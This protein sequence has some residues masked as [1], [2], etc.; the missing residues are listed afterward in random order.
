M[1]LLALLAPSALPLAVQPETAEVRALA[2]AQ[3]MLASPAH[4]HVLRFPVVRGEAAWRAD[5]D[6]P[7]WV[8]VE[9]ASARV[10]RADD[11]AALGLPDHEPADAAQS[12]AIGPRQLD[13]AAWPIARFEGVVRAPCLGPTWAEGSLFLLGWQLP[14]GGPVSLEP[15]AEGL[16]S[17]MALAVSQRSA[18]ITPYRIF[19]GL[20]ALDDRVELSTDLHWTPAGPAAR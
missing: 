8:E 16:R 5:G 4:D 20:V 6:C 9:V 3:G 11:R 18:G 13:A 15:T 7:F 1:D 12:W 10:D 19:L 14:A 17:R 2:T